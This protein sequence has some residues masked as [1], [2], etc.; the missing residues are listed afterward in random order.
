MRLMPRRARSS[1]QA[2]MAGVVVSQV[3]ENIP[4]KISKLVYVSAYLPRNGEDLL[5]LSKQDAQSKVGTALE[6]APDYSAASIKK[7]RLYPLFVPI[8]QRLDVR[9]YWW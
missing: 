1:L 3:A 9:R 4:D 5:S 2:S 7:R 8:V 6:F